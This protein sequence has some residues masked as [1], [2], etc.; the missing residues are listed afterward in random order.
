MKKYKVLFVVSSLVMS[1]VA[2]ASSVSQSGVISAIKEGQQVTCVGVKKIFKTNKDVKIHKD[3]KVE[4]SLNESGGIEA[5]EQD[6]AD[7]GGYSPIPYP[8]KFV[9]G[10]TSQDLNITNEKV[11][12]CKDDSYGITEEI[13]L[14]KHCMITG[15]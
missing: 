8:C 2:Y 1:V 15:R 4:L 12:V 3:Y 13:Y 5:T 14:L 10:F 6:T 11:F 7:L 9:D